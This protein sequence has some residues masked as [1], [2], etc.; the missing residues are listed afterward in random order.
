MFNVRRCFP[1]ATQSESVRLRMRLK[2]P[3]GEMDSWQWGGESG[4]VEVERNRGEDGEN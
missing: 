2:H 4:K 1:Q 3:G